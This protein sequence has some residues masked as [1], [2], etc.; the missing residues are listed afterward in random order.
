MFPESN[1]DAARMAF[2][3]RSRGLAELVRLVSL[4]SKLT[5]LFLVA[6]CLFYYQLIGYELWS[7]M[8]DLEKIGYSDSWTASTDVGT[9]R[10][11]MDGKK[12]V[13]VFQFS[14]FLL[15]L[16]LVPV[17]GCFGSW[18]LHTPC[19]GC[20]TACSCIYGMLSLVGFFWLAAVIGSVVGSI[21]ELE[22]YLHDCDP[23]VC[24][25]L[26][27]ERKQIDCFAT[28]LPSYRVKGFLNRNPHLPK[29]CPRVFLRCTEA[30]ELQYFEGLQPTIKEIR[31]QLLE[32]LTQIPSPHTWDDPEKYCV[33]DKHWVRVFKNA[34][35]QELVKAYSPTLVAMLC[36]FMVCLIPM[37]FL[38][39]AGGWYGKELLFRLSR[40]GTPYGDDDLPAH[41]AYHGQEIPGLRSGI[42]S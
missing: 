31:P 8:E 26:P 32:N 1:P 21:P 2:Q 4:I 7:F 27:S 36:A 19:L 6:S 33:V 17:C 3:D 11:F 22:R 35:E 14:F 13:A 30:K 38:S 15:L 25:R 10:H 40:I 39:C 9:P 29:D 20:F 5:L 34:Q 28:T 12:V 23:D 16:M 18:K 24:L 41:L 42:S 37:S